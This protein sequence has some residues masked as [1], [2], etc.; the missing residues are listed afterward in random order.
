MWTTEEI[1]KMKLPQL[2]E[3]AAK[4]EIPRYRYLKKGELQQ[5]ILQ[6]LRAQTEAPE[7][8][9]A[10]PQTPQAPQ[11]TAAQPAHP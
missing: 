1:E 3:V 7:N 2:Q 5:H 10:E 11:D 6:A 9:P 8:P 4:M